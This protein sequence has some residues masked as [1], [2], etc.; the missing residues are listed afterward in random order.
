VFGVWS[1]GKEKGVGGRSGGGV[2]PLLTQGLK[3]TGIRGYTTK[4]RQATYAGLYA[5]SAGA[6]PGFLRQVPSPS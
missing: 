1:I 6:L 2:F 5:K 3:I 4:E